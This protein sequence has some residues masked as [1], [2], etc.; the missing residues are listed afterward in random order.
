[1]GGLSDAP[2]GGGGGGRAWGLTNV[3]A[4]KSVFTKAMISEGAAKINQNDTS[5][6]ATGPRK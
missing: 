4:P 5:S 2:C 1:M 6:K 3:P